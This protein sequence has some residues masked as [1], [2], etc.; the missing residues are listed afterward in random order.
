MLETALPYRS[1]HT[2]PS[3]RTL[4]VNCFLWLLCCFLS[5]PIQFCAQDLNQFT[6][7]RRNTFSDGIKEG[8]LHEFRHVFQSDQLSL[9]RFDKFN[10]ARKTQR[11]L[12]F[13]GLGLTGAGA[14]TSLILIS[15]NRKES[16]SA[17]IVV[18][19]LGIMAIGP[20]IIIISNPIAGSIKNKR[21][22]TLLN[23]FINYSTI[24]NHPSIEISLAPNVG[25]LKLIVHF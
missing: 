13:T 10:N 24:D 20:A 7:I 4:W 2:F 12:N 21:K 17:A 8:K 3:K 11:I 25:G 19:V 1:R 23:E 15:E 6:E 9:D 18:G 16:Q 22:R 14:I 5:P